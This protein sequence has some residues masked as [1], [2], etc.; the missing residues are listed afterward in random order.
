MSKLGAIGVDVGGTTTK[1]AIVTAEGELL[2]R[3]ERPTEKTAATKGL[4]AIVDELIE[5]APGLDARVAAIGVGAAGFV[6]GSTIVFS[7]NLT[8]DDPQLGTALEVRTGLP[9]SVDNDANAAAWGER[10]FGAA[11]GS[12]H[13]VL[14]TLGTG[15]GSGFIVEG[16]IVRGFSG[17]GAEFGHT[18]IDPSGPL[19]ECGLKGCVEQFVSGT[20]IARMGREAAAEDPASSM[21]SFAGAVEDITAEHVSRAARE[22][23]ETARKVL[24]R[25]GLALGVALSNVANLFDPEVIVLAGSVTRAGEPFLGP[26][27]DEL[28]RMTTAQRRRPMRLDL[29]TLEGDGGI[30]GA[31]ALALELVG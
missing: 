9:V 24:R 30:L 22:Y 28:A 29:S 5:R 11:Q 31:G 16:R 6:A 12:D 19:C 14:I 26:A 18:V 10:A 23:D 13:L 25:A 7:P 2:G 8:Y 27:R 4:L 1:A 17:A 15:A 20:A 21:V 3:L